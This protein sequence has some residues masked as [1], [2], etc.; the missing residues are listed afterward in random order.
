VYA[1]AELGL[2][3]VLSP[4]PPA[5]ESSPV[6]GTRLMASTSQHPAPTLNP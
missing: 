5:P 3:R 4:P 1:V 2:R 6:T